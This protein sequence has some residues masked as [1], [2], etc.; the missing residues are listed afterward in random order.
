VRPNKIKQMWRDGRFVTLGWLSV[1]H[2]FTAEVMARQGFDALCVDMQHGTTDMSDV[3][4]ML[5]AISQT[6]TVP[7]VRVPWN[8]PATIMKALDLGAYGII[9]P[10]INTADDAAKA[11]AA[12][13]YPPVGM[14]S[15]G[16][17]RAVHYGG[18]DYLAK[19][20]DEIVVMA[21]IETKEGLANLDA[22]CATKG[23]DAV[24]GPRS[25]VHVRQ[26]PRYGAQ[27]RHQG[28]HAL[29]ECGVRGRLGQARLRHDHADVRPGVDDRGGPPS[30][31]RAEG[32]HRLT[33][34][35]PRKAGARMTPERFA[36]G[37]T[38]DDYVKFTGSPE[39][40]GREG[41]DVRRFSLVRP[42]VDW[43]GFLR[44]RY[45]NARLTD[46]Q[47][48]AITWLAAQPGAP[49]K[50]LVLSEDWSSDCRR[51]VPYLARLA[52]AGGL[53]LRIFVRDGDTMLRKGLPAPS[54]GGNAD[55]VLEYA[56]EKNGERW[57]TVPVAV[58]FTRD[59]VELY[60]YIEY[61]A[62]YHK[63]RVLGLLRAARAGET[64]EQT[65]AR[66]GRD[67]T[68]LLESPFFDVWARA[69]IAEILS[70]LHER[71]LTSSR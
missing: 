50:V 26:D 46:D 25:P 58:F 9:V 67:I 6:E 70:A 15:S 35:A 44:E 16:P 57:A 18:S 5:Q 1:S 54:A 28:G 32:R 62:I 61:P 59:F 52:E 10:L 29:R 30:A 3:W 66:S 36:R 4:P 53:E 24:Y 48:A 8:D 71:L 65:K 51:D 22:I 56:N 21:M 37:M 23:L 33:S 11:V 7:V 27:A 13:R 17:V 39:N 41:F 20:N 69:G 68:A 47:K 63:D 45:A 60:R 49:T 64:E 43:S 38:F 40:L 19:A 42:R 34:D 2:G 55:L 14:R 31:R 12:C